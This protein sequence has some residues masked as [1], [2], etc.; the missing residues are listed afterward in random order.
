[1]QALN[2]SWMSI[3]VGA[4][5]ASRGS[6]QTGWQRRVIGLPVWVWSA[7]LAALMLL[8]MLAAFQQVVALAV[9][10]GEARRLATAAITDALW[11]CNAL[12][13]PGRRASC[14]AQFA[15]NQALLAT[16]E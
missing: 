13:D 11:R 3:A 8:A 15:V 2:P 7:I 14:H 10:Q 6:P 4:S 9:H 12:R 16:Q 5:T 1:M